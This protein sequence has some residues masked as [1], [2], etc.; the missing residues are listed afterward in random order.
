MLCDGWLEITS[1][2]EGAGADLLAKVVRLRREWEM[3]LAKSLDPGAS[4]EEKE[5]TVDEVCVCVCVCVCLRLCVS[6]C[7]N[8]CPV[9]SGAVRVHAECVCA[10]NVYLHPYLCSVLCALIWRS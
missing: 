10:I 8:I 2:T 3:A 7:C 4:V 9:S 1:K 5:L 6:V